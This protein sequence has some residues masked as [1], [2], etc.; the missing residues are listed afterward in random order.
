MF[1]DG[2][3]QAES[4]LDGKNGIVDFKNESTFK[5]WMVNQ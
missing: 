1:I 3:L 4:G 2:I 5:K